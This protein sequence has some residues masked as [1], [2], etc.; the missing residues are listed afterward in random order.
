MQY[1][2]GFKDAVLKA[3]PASK[4]IEKALEKGDP[5]LSAYLVDGTGETLYMSVEHVVEKLRAGEADELLK[6]AEALDTRQNL[7]WQCKKYE[8]L[9]HHRP[10]AFSR[11]RHS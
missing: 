3:F 6:E 4:E 9:E 7:Y 11:F 8:N 10:T 5:M 2:Q 1:P